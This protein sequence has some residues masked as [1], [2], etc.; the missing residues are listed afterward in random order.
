[1]LV[2]PFFNIVHLFPSYFGTCSYHEIF[3]FHSPCIISFDS[4]KLSVEIP[5]GSKIVDNNDKISLFV[6]GS[7]FVAGLNVNL[8]W[9][10][11][12]IIESAL[13]TMGVF[14]SRFSSFVNIS[15]FWV[16]F[17]INIHL[18]WN[19]TSLTDI[20]AEITFLSKSIKPLIFDNDFKRMFMW[21]FLFVACLIS[22]WF[23]ELA[24]I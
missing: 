23:S 6:L 12:Q 15:V 14:R 9:L 22:S 3:N 10:T 17:N 18:S 16:E 5:K 2:I 20:H 1:M 7:S 4:Y 13:S 8:S 11:S 19:A 21:K 24:F